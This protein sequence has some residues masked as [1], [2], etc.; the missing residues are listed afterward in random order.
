MF[1]K[2]L[3]IQHCSFSL[4]VLWMQLYKVDSQR[5]SWSKRSAEHTGDC[6]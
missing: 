2:K 4:S 6:R 3:V 1:G 5:T